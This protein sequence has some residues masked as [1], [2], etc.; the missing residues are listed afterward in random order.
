MEH[1]DTTAKKDRDV[2]PDEK[3]IIRKGN[4]ENKKGYDD[5]IGSYKPLTRRPTKLLEVVA[6]RLGF[7]F[8]KNAKDGGRNPRSDMFCKFIMIMGMTPMI[9]C[10]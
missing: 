1:I 2:K 9:A 10:I 6:H 3:E 8:P 5:R 7:I 4:P